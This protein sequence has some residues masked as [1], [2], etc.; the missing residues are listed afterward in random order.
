MHTN[1]PIPEEAAQ[2][3]KLYLS[4]GSLPGD[5]NPLV[6]IEMAKQS[7][8]YNDLLKEAKAIRTLRQRIREHALETGASGLTAEQQI[9]SYMLATDSGDEIEQLFWLLESLEL[10]KA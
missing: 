5:V 2:L 8:E 6:L 10:E 3:L 4:G 1:D 7:G 9:K